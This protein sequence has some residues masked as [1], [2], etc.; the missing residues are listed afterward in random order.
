MHQKQHPLHLRKVN[1]N[2]FN[3][4]MIEKAFRDRDHPVTVPSPSF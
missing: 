2:Y 1:S 4:D 3:H